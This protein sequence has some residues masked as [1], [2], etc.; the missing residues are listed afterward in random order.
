MKRV[1]AL[2]LPLLVGVVVIASI[3][4]NQSGFSGNA[5]AALNDYLS[6]KHQGFQMQE[7][8]RAVHPEQFT[9]A[10][11]TLAFGESARYRTVYDATG[12]TSPL[13]GTTVVQLPGGDSRMP[14]PFPPADAWCVTLTNKQAASTVVVVFHQDLYN[15]AW[16]VHEV[17]TEAVS[18]IGCP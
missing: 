4:V 9:P 17:I 11:S 6:Y 3:L 13:A 1:I 5:R 8:R 12:I 16:I 18:A 15:G 2:M 10:M 14:L 7:V